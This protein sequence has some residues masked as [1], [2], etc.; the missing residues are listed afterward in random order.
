LQQLLITIFTREILQRFKRDSRES[1][2]G[3]GGWL[4]MCVL[5]VVLT[6]K[7]QFTDLLRVLLKLDS[8]DPQD[9]ESSVAAAAAAI[10]QPALRL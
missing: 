6:L 8:V 2:L 4:C 9:D 1:R 5:W 7:I 10:L 3:L